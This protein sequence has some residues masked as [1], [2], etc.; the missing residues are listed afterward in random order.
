MKA[1]TKKP[2]F[3]CQIIENTI[4]VLKCLPGN[5]PYNDFV[6]LETI[7]LPAESMDEKK[8]T[9][10]LS[11]ALKKLGFH[12]NE[13]IV[14]FP[15]ANTTCRY[16]KFPTH[17]PEEIDKMLSLQAAK[18]LPYSAQ[19]LITAYQVIEKDKDGFSVIN[20][21]IAHKET[22]QRS[23]RIFN[24]FKCSQLSFTLSSYGISNLYCR[25]YPEE[26]SPVMLL[27][28]D[29]QLV[30]LIIIANNKI[31]FNRY[32]KLSGPASGWKNL[33]REEI[34]KT[35]DAFLKEVGKTEPQKIVCLGTPASLTRINEVL[36]DQA[37]PSSDI[38]T[39]PD[40]LR[41]PDAVTATLANT[42]FS[43]VS[44]FG[45]GGGSI[46]ESLKLL[47]HE[48]KSE[49]IK[50][51]KRYA[52]LRIALLII[53]IIFMVSAAIA[54]NLNT[55]TDYL[56][57]LKAELSRLATEAKPLEEMDTRLKILETRSEKRLSSL[58]VFYELNNAVPNTLSLTSLIYEENSQI[59]LH[60]QAQ[61]LSTV[62]EFISVLEKLPIFRNFTIKVKYATQNKSQTGDM[63]DFEI[64][65]NNTKGKQ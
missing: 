38:R 53:G 8:I 5:T 27:D 15:R 37:I 6:A 22:L 50:L 58:E 40:Q 30:E 2:I 14:S 57:R 11:E 49:H 13:I 63:V 52:Y 29:G 31:L 19:E 46:E 45:L 36:N 1:K 4:R 7:M 9:E 10:A 54:K 16:L 42:P 20:A 62:F 56:N 61:T 25:L 43:Y 39:F 35:N 33:L 64:A 48:I 41:L 17:L 26:I 28:I 21:I 47:P 23:L 65:C 51:S 60:G 24:S 59:I 18:Y 34:I 32:F 55:K 3:V 44:M 12:K